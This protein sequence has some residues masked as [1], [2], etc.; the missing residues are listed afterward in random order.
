[1]DS[2][3]DSPQLTWRAGSQRGASLATALLF[4]GAGSPA[5]EQGHRARACPTLLSHPATTH[6]MGAADGRPLP[7]CAAS[8]TLPAPRN[9]IAQ[10]L[11]GLSYV[12]SKLKHNFWPHRCTQKWMVLASPTWPR[13]CL[14]DKLWARQGSQERGSFPGPHC[15]TFQWENLSEE[16]PREIW[17]YV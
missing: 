14:P 12:S 15:H 5:V 8:P 4:A 2:I 17:F 11:W 13:H 10:R 1:M 6:L 9:S 7:G 3:S 16:L